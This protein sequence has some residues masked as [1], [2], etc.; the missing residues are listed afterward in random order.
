V[1]SGFITPGVLSAARV[2]FYATS[3][4]VIPVYLLA[5][6]VQLRAT[7][8]FVTRASLDASSR[9]A[10]RVLAGFV[11]VLLLVG[12]LLA[13][14]ALQGDQDDGSALVGL[15]VF[16]GTLLVFYGTYRNVTAQLSTPTVKAPPDGDGMSPPD[17]QHPY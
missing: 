15:A 16:L 5:F 9:L 8:V 2:A 17:V 4:T 3:A 10:A 14:N 1:V 11:L 7:S 13:I 6:A 12:E